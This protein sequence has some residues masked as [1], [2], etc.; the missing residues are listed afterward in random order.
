[1]TLQAGPSAGVRASGEQQN[2]WQANRPPLKANRPTT[3][4]EAGPQ[5]HHAQDSYF[6]KTW[7]YER[8]IIFSEIFFI[9]NLKFQRRF[10]IW[11]KSLFSLFLLSLHHRWRGVSCWFRRPNLVFFP[12][13]ILC[14]LQLMKPFHLSGKHFVLRCH[15]VHALL[16]LPFTF[17]LHPI[18]FPLPSLISAALHLILSSLL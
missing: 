16:L 12:L 4:G 9:Q 7:S 8:Q 15:L 2:T 13:W 10:I 17:F 11:R 14:T 1:M 6:S 5:N 3:L 18:S